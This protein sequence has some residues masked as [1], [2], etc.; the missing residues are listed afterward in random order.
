VIFSQISSKPPSP[1]ETKHRKKRKK[2]G[3]ER[4]APRVTSNKGE[5]YI[6]RGEKHFNFKNILFNVIPFSPPLSY[7]FKNPSQNH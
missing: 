4:K 3:R 2:R 1:E 7:H 5:V 6:L